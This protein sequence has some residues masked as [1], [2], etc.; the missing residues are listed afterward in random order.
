MTG[1]VVDIKAEINSFLPRL[2]FVRVFLSQHRNPN[3]DSQND[4]QEMCLFFLQCCSVTYML[5]FLLSVLLLPTHVKT[6]FN[7]KVTKLILVLFILDVCLGGLF[8]PW[9]TWGE[10]RTTS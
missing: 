9:H 2:I 3:S 4:V 10:Q 7:I 5:A 1:H 8:I 6:T